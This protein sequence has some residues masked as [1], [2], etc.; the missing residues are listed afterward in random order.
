MSLQPIVRAWGN[1][2]G[3]EHTKKMHQNQAATPSLQQPHTNV[4]LIIRYLFEEVRSQPCAHAS[5]PQ[6]SVK[7]LDVEN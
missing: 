7:A 2:I 3:L 4:T 1:S 5:K 6:L